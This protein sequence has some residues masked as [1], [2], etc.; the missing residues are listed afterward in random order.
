M[1]PCS[2]WPHSAIKHQWTQRGPCQ[3]W[4]TKVEAKWTQ[5]KKGWVPVS[6]QYRHPVTRSILVLKF[7]F[8][9]IRALDLM[10]WVIS[11]S[12]A[13]WFCDSVSGTKLA[14]ISL[15]KKWITV[16]TFPVTCTKAGKEKTVPQRDPECYTPSLFQR[17]TSTPCLSQAPKFRV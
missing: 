3:Q 6:S 5:T 1:W 14:L 7:T 13:L 16:S 2:S 15:R 8:C 4:L 12:N 11:C 9:E 10:K 17:G